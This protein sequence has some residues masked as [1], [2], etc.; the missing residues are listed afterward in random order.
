MPLTF[1]SNLHN[2]LVHSTRNTII[3]SRHRSSNIRTLLTK[4]LHQSIINHRNPFSNFLSL[5]PR[6][7]CTTTNTL[8]K[9]TTSLATLRSSMAFP[10]VRH[11][12]SLLFSLTVSACLSYMSV[13]SLKIEAIL[14]FASIFGVI[15]P[16]EDVKR[17]VTPGP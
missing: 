3:L 11:S 6:H 4:L 13:L 7:H 9:T 2:L 15:F 14:A 10:F 17:V 8:N 5:I 12:F 1:S 16:V